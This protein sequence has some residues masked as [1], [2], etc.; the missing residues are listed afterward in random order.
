MLKGDHGEAIKAFEILM[1][2]YPEN[3]DSHRRLGEALMMA[4]RYDEARPILERG[5]EIAPDSPAL[6]DILRLLSEKQGGG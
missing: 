3:A 2:A 4:G 1:D 5:L 6:R